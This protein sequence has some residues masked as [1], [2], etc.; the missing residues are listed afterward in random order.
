[1]GFDDIILPMKLLDEKTGKLL[2]S[3]KVEFGGGHGGL[4]MRAKSA[5][6]RHRRMRHINRKSMD[7]LRRIPGGGVYYN[8][9]VMSAL[10]VRASNK[11]IRSRLRTMYSMLCS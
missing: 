5:D 3:I 7:V 10:S 2:Y 4:A 8:G 1:M 9:D 6:L 11:L